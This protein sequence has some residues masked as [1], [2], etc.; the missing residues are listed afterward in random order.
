MSVSGS[1]DTSE[2]QPSTLLADSGDLD[3][4]VADRRR[5][6]EPRLRPRVPE[7]I[8]DRALR[9]KPG[10]RRA[11][12]LPV[13]QHVGRRPEDLRLARRHHVRDGRDDEHG[14]DDHP[15]V[16][17]DDGEVVGDRLLSGARAASSSPHCAGQFV[18]AE[19]RSIGALLHEQEYRCAAVRSDDRRAGSSS[20][21]ARVSFICT[22][23]RARSPF[24]A[25]LLRRQLRD[26]PVVVESFGVLEQGGAPALPG[27][28]RA[29]AA[30]GIDLSDHRARA[31]GLR[32]ARG[33]RSSR[34]ASSRPTW[35]RRSRRAASRAERAFLLAELA[36]VLEVDVLPWPADSDDSRAPRRARERATVRRRAAAEVGRG[37]RRR[38]GP[39]VPADVRGD[40]PDG[41]DHRHAAL[42]RERCPD[43]LTRVSPRVP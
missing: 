15:L 32:R 34:S 20:H 25:A 21:V 42:R 39:A 6:R 26:L 12:V 23:N 17:A 36:D 29:A 38:L 33:A 43:G 10:D 30:F 41:R 16:A 40:R 11:E 13:E 8:G 9:R 2:P 3:G 4:A 19:F 14:D 28:V 18:F 22:A 5:L 37:S 31:L 35:R 27:A 7:R 24:A 1:A